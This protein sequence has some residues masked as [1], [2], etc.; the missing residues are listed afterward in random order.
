M[1][2]RHGSRHRIHANPFAVRGPMAKLDMEALFGRKAPLALD[3]GF[4]PGMFLL[5]L[6]EKYPQWNVLGM[7]IRQHFVDGVMDGAKERGLQNVHALVAN[8]NTQLDDCLADGC[9]H[10]LSLNFPDPWFKKRHQ[11]RRVMQTSWLDLVARKMAV[12]SELHYVSDFGPGAEEALLL[13]GEHP[14]FEAVDGD[15][16]LPESSTGI[17]TEREITHQGRG[18]TIYRLHYRRRAN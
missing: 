3:V 12:G 1:T 13:L 15:R 5:G 14:A 17:I 8:A 7:E 18:D 11:K 2:R 6:A 10:F 9:L 4:G 16:F